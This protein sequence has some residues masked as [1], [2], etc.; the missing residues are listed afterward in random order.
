MKNL[1]NFAL[2]LSLLFSA[3]M[4]TACTGDITANQVNDKYSLKK[5]VIL[6][7]EHVEVDYSQ[8]LED[9]KQENSSWQSKEVYLYIL[10]TRGK[11]HLHPKLPFLDNQQDLNIRDQGSGKYIR[12]LVFEAAKNERGNHIKYTLDTTRIAYVVPFRNREEDTDMILVGVLPLD[13]N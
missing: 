2:S 1:K 13:N 7:R 4:I 8:A 10:D 11:I 5:F 6:A 3:G 9:F 12:D